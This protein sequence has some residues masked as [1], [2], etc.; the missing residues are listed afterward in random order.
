MISAAGPLV[1]LSVL[2]S[3]RNGVGSLLGAGSA[4]VI[5]QGF[6]QEYETEADDKGWQYL[7]AAHI[8]PRG[9]ISTFQKFE[10]WEAADPDNK[11]SLPQAFQSHP[12]LKKRIS[13]LE[14]KER[15]LKHNADFQTLNME[16][17]QGLKTVRPYEKEKE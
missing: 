1:I 2:L 14:S 5:M 8:D 12:A 13:R 6:S 3:G 4:M 9:M 11:D 17:W 15:R 10:V 16:A 7:V